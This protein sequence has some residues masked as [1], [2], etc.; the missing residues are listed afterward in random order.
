[1]C[2]GFEKDQPW[3]GILDILVAPRN[4]F[5]PAVTQLLMLRR[6][7]ARAHPRHRAEAVILKI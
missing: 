7:A 1:M 5:A 4:I 2:H 6:P 3:Q